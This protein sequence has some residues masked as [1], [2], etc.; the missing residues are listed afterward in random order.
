MLD[1]SYFLANLLCVFI[2]LFGL[3]IWGNLNDKQVLKTSRNTII[4]IATLSASAFLCSFFNFRISE[5]VMLNLSIVPLT[6]GFFALSWQRGVLVLTLSTAAQLAVFILRFSHGRSAIEAIKIAASVMPEYLLIILGFALIMCAC[7]IWTKRRSFSFK[8]IA[9]M[10]GLLLYSIL[11]FLYINRFKQPTD[12]HIWNFLGYIF[13]FHFTFFVAARLIVNSVEKNQAVEE[14]MLREEIYRRLVEDSPDAIA[15]SI[16]RQWRF[17]N[18]SLVDLFGG[19]NKE[20]LLAVPSY[21]FVHPDYSD[22]NKSRMD[23]VENGGTAELAEQVLLKLNGEPFYA[24][25]ISIPTRYH[26]EQ[27]AHTIIRDITKRREEQSLLVQ[28]E[29]LR[30]AGQLAAGIAHEIRNP[31][32]AI[33]GFLKLIRTNYKE[34]YLEVVSEEIDRIE[35]IL[36]ELLVLAKPNKEQIEQVDMTQTLKQIVTLLEPQANLQNIAFEVNYAADRANILCDENQLKQAFINF[37]KNAFEA[38][39][40]GG[41]VKIQTANVGDRLQIEFIDGGVGIPPDKLNNLGDPFFT[42]KESG[43]GLGFMVSKKIIEDHNGELTVRSAVGK[44]TIIR[45]LFPIVVE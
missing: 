21:D 20:Q 7:S 11:D 30:V 16:G 19:E 39:P 42:T 26:G 2:P 3:E 45:A 44:G 12:I 43:T 25:T 10:I 22:M 15:I 27:A 28:A 17:I 31:L 40:E 29:K 18:Q 36:T 41:T 8:A 34:Q 6:I 38:M 33:K 14:I 24:E 13:V 23:R 37:L 4:L 1:A 32:T 35:E 5:E 9:F